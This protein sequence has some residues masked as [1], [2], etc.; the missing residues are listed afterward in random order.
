[1]TVERYAAWLTENEDKKG[2]PDFE[3]VAQAYKVARLRAIAG[4]EPEKRPTPFVPSGEKPTTDIA[5]LTTADVVKGNP[6]VRAVTQFP[7]GAAKPVIAAAQMVGMPVGTRRAEEALAGPGTK[8]YGG[9]YGGAVGDFAGQVMSPINLGLAGAM[10]PVAEKAG[11]IVQGAVLGGAGG[12]LSEVSDPEEAAF[13]DTKL[14]QGAG[15]LTVGAALAPALAAGG[16]ALIHAYRSWLQPVLANFSPRVRETVKQRIYAVAAGEQAPQV[17]AGLR[18][19]QQLIPGSPPNA[20][21]A[22][23]AAGAPA[24]AAI[25]AS[26]ARADPARYGGR[27][28]EQAQSVL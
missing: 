14:V 20:G 12:I 16:P 25:Q 2:T 11:K 19:P 23:T 15:G 26:A 13:W 1:M 27:A 24:F 10:R 8:L 5:N 22:A 4:D 28:D 21:Q 17:L 3:T 7:L 6:A 18:N 9:D